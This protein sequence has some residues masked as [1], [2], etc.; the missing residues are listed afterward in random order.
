VKA[1]HL[2]SAGE[3]QPSA[4]KSKDISMDFIVGL[5]MTLKGFDSIL[6]IIDRLTKSAHFLLVQITYPANHYAK[7]YVE[8]IISLHG[9]PKTIVSDRGAQFI[10]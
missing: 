1:M 4:W 8:R 7:L 6:V 3:L 5:P 9:V 10:S 2:K